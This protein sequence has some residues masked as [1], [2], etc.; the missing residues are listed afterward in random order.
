M[1]SRNGQKPTWRDLCQR[2]FA[3]QAA[4]SRSE[5]QQA[6]VHGQNGR[7][8]GSDLSFLRRWIS[9]SRLWVA[10]HA[11]SLQILAEETRQRRCEANAVDL[12]SRLFFPTNVSF[13]FAEAEAGLRDGV[14]ITA[15]CFVADNISPP[16]RG[17]A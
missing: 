12:C 11:R 1:G 9:T 6:F 3:I 8:S 5:L 2:S 7:R 17:C 13:G 14:P 15:T 4:H 16:P 10:I